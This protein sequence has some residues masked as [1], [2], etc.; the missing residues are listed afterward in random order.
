MKA[1]QCIYDN[2]HRRSAVPDA[3][4]PVPPG[5]YDERTTLLAFCTIVETG[6][7][8]AQRFQPVQHIIYILYLGYGSETAHSKTD[9]LAHNG[10]LTYAGIK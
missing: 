10:Q 4:K 6:Y 1:A 9:A 2:G 8:I 5:T 7:I 3:F